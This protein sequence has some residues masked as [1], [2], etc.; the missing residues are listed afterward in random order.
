[1]SIFQFSVKLDWKEKESTL[2]VVLLHHRKAISNIKWKDSL[3]EK[4]N[5]LLLLEKHSPLNGVSGYFPPHP[6][7]PNH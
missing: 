1:M 2:I 5:F 4:N 6:C 3:R 7:S